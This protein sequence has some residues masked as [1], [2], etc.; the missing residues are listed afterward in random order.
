MQRRNLAAG[1]IF[2]AGCSGLSH[3][4]EGMRVLRLAT[5]EH[6]GYWTTRGTKVVGAAYQQLNI[7][8]DIT[9]L[10]AKR[11]LEASNAGDFDGELGRVAAIEQY[12]PNLRRVP[13]A[14]GTYVLTPLT[15]TAAYRSL[16]TIE[17]LRESGLHIGTMLGM[18]TIIDALHGIKVETAASPQSVLQMLASKRIDVAIL[19]QGSLQI[20]RYSLPSTARDALIEA[21]EHDP[22]QSAPLYHYLHKKNSELIPFVDHE[23]QKMTRNGAIKRIWAEPD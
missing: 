15:L 14:I 12:S 11:A 8:V 19:P 6:L 9:L 16:S 7:A 21:V 2:M 17:A 23:L 22:V 13:T 4:Q 3:A 18:R 5:P 20:W 10:P 1:L